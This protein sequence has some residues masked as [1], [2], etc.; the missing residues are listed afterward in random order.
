MR[1][2]AA[3][4]HYLDVET[5]GTTFS[6]EIAAIRASAKVSATDAICRMPWLRKAFTVE[7][8]R[9]RER[10]DGL[11]AAR[12]VPGLRVRPSTIRWF[13]L[14]VCFLSAVAFAAGWLVGLQR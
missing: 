13:W 1:G 12:A 10:L 3:A 8:E 4:A 14:G 11:E 5:R 9:I 7:A 6:G 2:I